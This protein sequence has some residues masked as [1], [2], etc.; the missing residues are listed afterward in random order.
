MKE[1]KSNAPA[2][3]GGVT[4]ICFLVIIVGQVVLLRGTLFGGGFVLS[5][6]Y[7]LELL[8]CLVMLAG[9]VV[10]FL[11]PMGWSTMPGVIAALVLFA[12]YAA[13]N[14]L[15][16]P[17]FSAAY[18]A[19]V[20]SAY[21]STGGALVGLKLVL[22]LVGVTA[23]IPVAAPIDK[24]EYSRRLREKAEMQNAQWAKAAV[25]GAAEDLDATLARLKSTLSEEEMAKL[26]ADLQET[27]RQHA[28]EGAEGAGEETLSEQYRGWGGGM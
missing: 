4:V 16:Y 13:V 15:Y 27:A 8:F 20:N 14:I 12:A 2:A 5:A 7:M 17:V 23:A 6:P 10:C 21:A 11:K 26:L 18:L 3:R 9:V 28:P 22:A 19:G 25:K 1:Q 24:R